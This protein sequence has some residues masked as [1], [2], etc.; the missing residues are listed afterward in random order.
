MACGLIKITAF[1]FLMSTCL[2]PALNL[3]EEHI[4]L[5][6]A[7]YYAFGESTN[8]SRH[9]H[10]A[11]W[12]YGGACAVDGVQRWWCNLPRGLKSMSAGQPFHQT[13]GLNHRERC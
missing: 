2:V 10:Q 6:P 8:A 3:A 7:V 5:W 12:E 13:S 1:T 4:L 9:Q 11:L